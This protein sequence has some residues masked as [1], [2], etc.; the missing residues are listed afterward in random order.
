MEVA[1]LKGANQCFFDLLKGFLVTP[2]LVLDTLTN[3]ST[4][5]G[6]PLLFYFALDAHRP[7]RDVGGSVIDWKRA[8]R[9]MSRSSKDRRDMRPRFSIA[10][11]PL[12]VRRTSAQDLAPKN[13]NWRANLCFEFMAENRTAG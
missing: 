2:P 1:I 11:A 9:I 12:T 3:Y 6:L 8:K 7:D 4:A 10:S 5:K 13:A